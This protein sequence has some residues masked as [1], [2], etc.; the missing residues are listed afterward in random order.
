MKAE[1]Q[2]R[3]ADATHGSGGPLRVSDQ[4]IHWE[5]GDHFIAA[6]VEAGLPA[7][8]DFNDG[9][10]EG[11]GPFQNTTDRRRRWSTATAYLRPARRRANLVVRTNAQAT[12]I[13]AE[14]GKPTGGG[15]GARRPPICG[16]RAAAPTL[17]SAPTRRRRASSSRRARRPASSLSAAA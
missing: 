13:L 1:D 16:R 2:E 3:G 11:A 4:A 5:L 6:A 17:W 12:R 10:Q 8:N 15:A 14:K 9:E 7:N